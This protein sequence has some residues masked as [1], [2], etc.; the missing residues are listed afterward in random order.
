MAE[1]IDPDTRIEGVVLGP[2][3]EPE[4]FANVN[5]RW[6]SFF[7]SGSSSRSTDEHGRFRLIVPA[8]VKTEMDFRQRRS[9]TATAH[10][11]RVR[12]G[13]LDLRVQLVIP[14][15]FV[16]ALQNGDG[17]PTTAAA[18]HVR[19][20]DDVEGGDMTSEDGTF[21]VLALQVPFRVH[22]RV[23]GHAEA[24]SEL[25]DPEAL[26]DVVKLALRAIPTVHGTVIANGRPV[27]GSA[28]AVRALSTETTRVAELPSL[29]KPHPVARAHTNVDGQFSMTLRKPDSYML[30]AELVGFAPAE[31]GPFDHVPGNDRDAIVIELTEGGAIEGVVLDGDGLRQ[32]R[33]VLIS[34]GDGLVQTVRTDP[35]GA[36]RFDHLTPGPWMVRIVPELIDPSGSSSTGSWGK[37][38]RD[39]DA[40]C[41]V[42]EG[43][44]TR[45][46][47]LVGRLEARVTVRGQVTFSGFDAAHMGVDLVPLAGNRSSWSSPESNRVDADGAFTVRG[48]APGPH[49]LVLFD[50]TEDTE[51]DA[52]RFA[53]QL[54][55]TAGENAFALDVS[56]G[57]VSV[58]DAADGALERLLWRGPNGVFAIAPLPEDGASRPF[59]AGA[60]QRVP[61]ATI[62]LGDLNAADVLEEV[63]LEPGA[64]VVVGQ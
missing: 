42:L 60:V 5:A 30:R 27:E 46:D 18:I 49:M 58:G 62:A 6:R 31:F 7:S 33:V 3:G 64:T 2:D 21:E 10:L 4:P 53:V 20:N 48:G 54:E 13:T 63:R 23:E 52:L 1:E 22:V 36:Y 47:P 45:F 25:L 32:S 24:T 26:P 44:A 16:V 51:D 15:R 34:R 40:D 61:F 9:G 35:D 14:P 38:F 43:E 29:V 41:F 59:P 37:P 28:I 55:L 8:R 50:A 39:F 57:E 19:S 12:G 56:F 17:T 11:D